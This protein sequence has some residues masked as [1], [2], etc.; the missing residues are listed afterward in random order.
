LR[1]ERDTQAREITNLRNIIS[2]MSIV[3]KAVIEGGSK[4]ENVIRFNA[5]DKK[6]SKSDEE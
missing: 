6:G 2:E 5:D 1:K 4:A 3:G